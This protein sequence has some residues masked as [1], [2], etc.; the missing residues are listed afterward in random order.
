MIT[1]P[2]QMAEEVDARTVAC[3]TFDFIPPVKRGS[4]ECWLSSTKGGEPALPALV[5]ILKVEDGSFPNPR[6]Y[7]QDVEV[8][9]PSSRRLWLVLAYGKRI[10]LTS[11]VRI[12]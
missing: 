6:F 5:R 1:L 3:G 4:V 7:K 9:L 12:P 2:E 10:L 11:P 8:V